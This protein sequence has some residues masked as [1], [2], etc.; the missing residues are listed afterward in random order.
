MTAKDIKRVTKKEISEM[1]EDQI[2]EISIPL[3]WSMKAQEV[4]NRLGKLKGS[5]ASTAEKRL[6]DMLN[7]QPGLFDGPFNIECLVEKAY[8]IQ[9]D[10][11]A[12]TEDY[13]Q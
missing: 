13:D 1:T 8:E 9:G 3:T 5:S 12:Y 10:K 6:M 2:W 7:I 4:F 11:I